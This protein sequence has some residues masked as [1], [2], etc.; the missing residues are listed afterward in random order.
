[1]MEQKSA[2]LIVDAEENLWITVYGRKISNERPIEKIQMMKIDNEILN[3][4][5]ITELEIRVEKEVT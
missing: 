5:D 2:G 4:R 1:M 3:V